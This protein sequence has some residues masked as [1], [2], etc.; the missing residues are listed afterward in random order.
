MAWTRCRAA[1]RGLGRR[2]ASQDALLDRAS[3][4]GKHNV[5]TRIALPAATPL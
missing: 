5:S 3:A 2:L 4:E 1:D